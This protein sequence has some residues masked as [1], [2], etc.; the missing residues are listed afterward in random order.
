MKKFT[1]ISN[2]V[3]L[4]ATAV[5][6]VLFFTLKPNVKPSE[7]DSE[8]QITAEKGDIVFI[9]LDS[10]VNQYDMYNDLKSELEGKV[11]AIENDLNKKG[12]ALENDIKSFE[13][14]M[15]KGLLTRSQAEAMNNDLMKRQQEIQGLSQ[16]KGNEMAEE[17]RV[18][19]NKVMDA[20]ATY[21]REYNREHRY[22]LILTT[23]AATN[24][25]ITGDRGLNITEEIL[26]GI[27]AQYITTRNKK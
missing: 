21:I 11:S 18:M 26:N 6:Y 4:A 15:N 10:L 1:I 27:N 23:S 5:L 9:Q 8:S 22:S 19:I 24:T 12:R 13:E 20:I 7:A 17:E 3:L 2:I 16:Q 25:V 14:K